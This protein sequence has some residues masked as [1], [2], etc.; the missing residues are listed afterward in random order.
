MV[1][2]STEPRPI[3]ILHRGD[4]QDESGE[5]VQPAVPAFMGDLSKN[6]KLTQRATR[7]DLALLANNS[8][9]SGRARRTHRSRLCQ[10]SLVFVLRRR[11][12]PQLG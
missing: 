2:Q 12:L 5:T 3:K 10:S 1:S 7:L 8:Q 11:S 9:G 4:W 6:F